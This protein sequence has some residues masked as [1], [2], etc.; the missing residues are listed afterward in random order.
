MERNKYIIKVFIFIL[1]LVIVKANAGETLL[2]KIKAEITNDSLFYS[3]VDMQL[4]PSDIELN[5]N[6]KTNVF[7]PISLILSVKSNILDGSINAN[8]YMYT[9][10]LVNERSECI[11]YDNI[12]EKYS[13]PEVSIIINNKKEILTN[14][15]SSP[16]VFDELYS[17]N[18]GNTYLSDNI[19]VNL[20][21]FEPQPDKINKDFKLCEGEFTILAGIDL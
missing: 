20:M 9:I 17:D 15:P 11:T 2:F 1:T 18:I 8:K 3:I 16:I 13:K 5:Y 19:E 4:T 6:T 21:F 12:V 14:N 7:D 10:T